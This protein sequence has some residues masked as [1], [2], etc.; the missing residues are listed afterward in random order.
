MPLHPSTRGYGVSTQTIMAIQSITNFESSPRTVSIDGAWIDAS[1]RVNDGEGA[2]FLD[3]L[4]TDEARVDSV[5]TAIHI[6]LRAQASADHSMTGRLLDERLDRFIE[7]LTGATDEVMRKATDAFEDRFKKRVD[8]EFAPRLDGHRKAL[9]ERLEVLFGDSSDRSV[10]ERVRRFMNE[11]TE[12]V[13]ADMADIHG[14]VRKDVEQLVNGSG[15]PDHP[16]TKID[17]HLVEL[18]KDLAVELEA[19]RAAVAGQ[20]VRQTTG[21]AGYDYQDDVYGVIAETLKATDDEV[22]YKGRSPGATGGAEGDMVVTVNPALT[23][24]VPA[25]ISVEATKSS[26]VLNTAKVKAMLKKGREDRAAHAAVLVLRSPKVIGGQRLM[27][28]A[29][30]GV[31]VVYEP[32]DPEEFR[33]LALAVG[34][35]QAKAMAIRE[36]KPSAAERNDEAIERAGQEAK[37]A[38]DAVD[39]IIGY[40]AKIVKLAEATCGS[41]KDIRRRVLDAMSDIDDA[42]S[43]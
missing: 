15:K 43:S 23:G 1:V 40:Q 19:Q 5:V 30:L 11:F 7:Q 35:K 31:V 33:T 32:A 8:E 24:G 38:I 20:A 36:V 9:D 22:E 39:A 28:Y 41:A 6:G 12:Q 16:L 3:S 37:D 26:V 2:A 25:R 17:G 10:P 29:G 14:K 21:Q 13:K 27:T 4:A 42:L 18:R 34:M